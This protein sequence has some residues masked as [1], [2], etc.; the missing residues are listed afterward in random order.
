MTFQEYKFLILSDLYRITADTKTFTLI[1]Y[2]FMGGSYKYNFWMRTCS[3]FN[4]Y[5]LMKYTFY[6]IPRIIL[7]HYMYK[8]GIA[9]SPNTKIGSGFYI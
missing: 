7:H 4:K 9:I 3:F 2:L 1:R 8:F 6:P 5:K